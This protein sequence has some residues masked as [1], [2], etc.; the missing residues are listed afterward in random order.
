MFQGKGASTGNHFRLTTRSSYLNEVFSLRPREKN[1][2]KVK[3][4]CSMNAAQIENK[5]NH[6]CTAMRI[7]GSAADLSNVVLPGAVSSEPHGGRT[8][9]MVGVP[10]G[11][12][13]KTPCVQTCHH[14]GHVICLGARI[15]KIHHLLAPNSDHS[16]MPSATYILSHDPRS[17]VKDERYRHLHDRSQNSRGNRTTV[18]VKPELAKHIIM[19]KQQLMHCRDKRLSLPALCQRLVPAL[20]TTPGPI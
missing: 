20:A 5:G 18:P 4:F 17:S 3:V 15:H 9:A 10:Q 12:N 2:K 16:S 14:H 7:T 6:N 8:H 1:K 11:Y 19:N 13:V